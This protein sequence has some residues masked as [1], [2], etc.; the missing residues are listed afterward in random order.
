MVNNMSQITFRS[1]FP[2]DSL[3]IARLM[4]IAGGGIFEFLFQDIQ[5]EMTV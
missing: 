1:A 4:I 5:T 3:E 2:E